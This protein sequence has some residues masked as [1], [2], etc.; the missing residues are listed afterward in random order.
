MPLDS[1][2]CCASLD[3][4]PFDYAQGK[5]DRQRVARGTSFSPPQAERKKMEAGGVEPPS[6]KPR[7]QETTGVARSGFLAA[8]GR[9]RA[10][11]G[12]SQPDCFRSGG[13]RRRPEELARWVDA[14]SRCA[15][16]PGKTRYLIKQREPILGWQ[17][18][19]GARDS[20]H[21]RPGLPPVSSCF[22]RNRFAPT[23][24]RLQLQTLGRA[25]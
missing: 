5:R 9:E 22:R 6:E 25:S 7:W 23:E 14:L 17:L 4:A 18:L 2:L 19:F 8:A 12:S 21:V 20:G 15:G 3:C 16:S 10:R 1:A 24:T 13:L 11:P